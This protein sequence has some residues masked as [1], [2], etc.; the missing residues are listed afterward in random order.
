MTT[1]QLSFKGP[2]QL[3]IA[4]GAT[5]PNPGI[6]GV[7]VWSTT[8]GSMVI[9]DGSTWELLSSSSS[10][11]KLPDYNIPAG[12]IWQ[13]AIYAT[14]GNTLSGNVATSGTTAYA[15][16][17]AGSGTYQSIHPSHTY[18]S[19]A[20]TYS[21]A[22]VAG[23][24]VQFKRGTADYGGFLLSCAVEFT[25]TPIGSVGYA[26]LSIYD[27]IYSNWTTEAGIAIGFDSGDA[28]PSLYLMVGNGTTKSRTLLTR[29]GAGYAASSGRE[30]SITIS[31]APG[32]TTAKVSAIDLSN[33]YPMLSNFSVD[34]SGI[35]ADIAFN[36]V[37]MGATANQTSALS[38]RIYEA[39]CV[40][41]SDTITPANAD[42][43]VS[44]V[45]PSNPVLNQLWV[46]TP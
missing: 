17:E 43:T 2:P 41:F 1:R 16:P 4:A 19:A 12:Q 44:S 25:T 15:A 33:G 5:T 35:A 8:L 9:W 14:G 26:G 36:M 39:A 27:G 28:S 31:C 11:T 40:F 37:C 22:G 3:A 32:A 23:N 18:S 7:T 42:I 10:Y 46:Q 13:P 34:I 45:A 30:F 38:N 21:G 24:A 29:T 20:A 6:S